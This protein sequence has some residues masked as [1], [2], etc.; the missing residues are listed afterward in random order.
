MVKSEWTAQEILQDVF[1]K[2]WHNRE[3]I[4]IEKSFR[5]YLFKIAE[6][7]VYDFFRK[8]AGDKKL[9]AQLLA[10]ATEH[11]EHIEEFLLKKENNLLLQKAISSLSPQ[12]QQIFRMCKLEGKSY[13]EVSRQLDISTSTVSD[14]IV[15]AGKSVREY[16]LD[17]LDI[18]IILFCLS[19]LN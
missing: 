8:A 1:L 10:V 14:H 7:K 6:N 9:R 17:H 15:K 13:E 2:I 18:A 4:D 5:S 19:S 11:Y 16:L 12:R 3:S